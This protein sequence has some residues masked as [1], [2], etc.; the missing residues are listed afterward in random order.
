MKLVGLC[1]ALALQDASAVP[2]AP[3]TV[4]PNDIEAAARVVGA[5]FSEADIELMLADV[6]ENL[7]SYEKLRAIPVPNSLEPALYFLPARAQQGGGEVARLS[8]R[9]L[10]V[11]TPPARPADLA[12]LAYADISEL[13]RYV[14]SRVV[15]CVELTGLFLGRL[16]RLDPQLLCV[17]SLT[18]ERALAQARVLDEELA[19]GRSR[20]MLHG[21]PWV[22]KDLL[23]V[24]GTRTT[25]GA[26]PFEDQVI[27]DDAAVVERLDA[28]GAVLIAKV[29]LGALAWGDVWFGGKT[30]NPWNLEQG[31]SGSSAGPAAA[32]AAGCAPFAIGSETLGS[33]VSPSARCGNSSLRPTFGRISR[34]GAMTLSWSM[35]KLG[36]ICRSAADAALVFDAVH[37]A[38]PRDPTTVSLPFTPPLAAQGAPDVAGWKVGFLPG[39]AED[40][41]R[42]AAVLDDLR[43]LGAELVPVELPD[44][45]VRDMTF[46]L[47]AEA[48]TAFDEFSR[49]GRGAEMVRQ[50]RH[51]WPNVFRLAR[52]IPA[53]D[54]LRANRLRTLLIRDLSAALEGVRALVHP[55]FAGGLLSAT[56]LSGHPTFVAPYGFREDGTPTSVSFTAPLFGETDLLMLAVAWQRA[57]EHHLRHPEL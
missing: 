18:E 30:R 21:I 23:A 13:Q 45:P 57:T 5:S 38:D 46:V 31:S 56:N 40:D 53:V 6:T 19:A 4:D 25:W 51:A 34:H 52:L 26:K 12:E 14:Q 2:E 15:S 1:L 44:Y 39:A 22:A 55:S 24:R 41:A 17:I 29:T 7:A 33:I 48:A 20:G 50:E 42:Y 49:Q 43:G 10:D 16:K 54:Y 47:S 32:V 27:D 9:P 28:A 35:D 8:G 37:G 11:E 3:P 36:P